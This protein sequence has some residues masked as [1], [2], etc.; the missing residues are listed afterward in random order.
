MLQLKGK[1][2]SNAK[3]TR[4]INFS[5]RNCCFV[6]SVLALHNSMA[7]RREQS[8]MTAENNNKSDSCRLNTKVVLMTEQC[9]RKEEKKLFEDSLYMLVILKCLSFISTIFHFLY[10]AT[11]RMRGEEM[12]KR[13]TH[14]N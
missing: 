4:Y 9:W 1:N 11:G 7:G 12:I 13:H 2:S 14:L 5:S 10:K 8:I 3:F 6:S